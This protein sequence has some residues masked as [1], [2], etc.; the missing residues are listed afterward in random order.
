MPLP[1]KTPIAATTVALPRTLQ[2]KD[3]C[4]AQRQAR[5][6][7]HSL[8]EARNSVLA[9]AR[10]VHPYTGRQSSRCPMAASLPVRSPHRPLASLHSHSSTC[11]SAPLVT[12]PHARLP[13]CQPAHPSGPLHSYLLA[14]HPN[15]ALASALAIRHIRILFPV[16]PPACSPARLPA[17]SHAHPPARSH[18][19]PPARSHARTLA[20]P[21]AGLPAHSPK[22]MPSCQHTSAPMYLQAHRPVISVRIRLCVR[23]LPHQCPSVLPQPTCPPLPLLPA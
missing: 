12:S 9:R 20:R 6:H 5:M 11:P 17:R 7:T 19:H 16:C 10:L 18:A 1:A 8:A 23:P 22:R 21:L 15:A 4:T 14:S 2:C 13:A 3:G